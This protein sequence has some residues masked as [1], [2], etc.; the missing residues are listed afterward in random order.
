MHTTV[1]N[2][3][4]GIPS[5]MISTTSNVLCDLLA[6]FFSP[7]MECTRSKETVYGNWC[8]L[9]HKKKY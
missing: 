8:A 5:E 4:T 7:S 6:W 1:T 2:I 9:D 3:I